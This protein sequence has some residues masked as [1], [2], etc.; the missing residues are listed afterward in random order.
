[1][2]PLSPDTTPDAQRKHYE[3]MGGIEN[4]KTLSGL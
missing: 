4:G 3:L 1:M 2:K